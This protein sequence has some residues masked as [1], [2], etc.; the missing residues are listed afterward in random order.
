MDASDVRGKLQCLR[1]ERDSAMQHEESLSKRL[2]AAEALEQA[3]Q[4][5]LSALLR[6]VELRETE[7]EEQNV[8][9]TAVQEKAERASLRIDECEQELRRL[10]AEEFF[11]RGKMTQ[12]K[13]QREAG[14][15]LGL[16]PAA[17]TSTPGE[18]A[19]AQE[20]TGQHQRR[21]SASK[22]KHSQEDEL[23]Q[24]RRRIGELEDIAE[25]N[26]EREDKSNKR[27]ATLTAKLMDLDE[28]VNAKERLMN[29]ARVC[30]QKLEER[31]GKCSENLEA[32]RKRARIATDEITRLEKVL[33]NSIEDSDV[34]KEM[35]KQAADSL[36]RT[37]EELQ[38]LMDS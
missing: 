36:G 6:R 29:T 8:R 26:E 18:V 37:Q 25:E 34:W 16:G 2:K 1:S 24:L 7:L 20:N 11:R 23:G 22:S 19:A 30:E 28:N 4:S 15:A 17:M 9:L 21:V 10:Q 32:E 13:N 5:K 27:S 33:D 31:I 35:W 38:D 14:A 3:R 12:Q